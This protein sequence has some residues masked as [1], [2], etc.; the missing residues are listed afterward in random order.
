MR[1][2]GLRAYSARLVVRNYKLEK[3]S[4]SEGTRQTLKIL[5]QLLAEKKL[6]LGLTPN[7]T[8]M[9]LNASKTKIL[10]FWPIT[11]IRRYGTQRIRDTR[12]MF[13]EVSGLQARVCFQC[14]AA[15]VF[16][17]LT[18]LTE[19]LRKKAVR[20]ESTLADQL[21]ALGFTPKP[22]EGD[23]NCQFRAVAD[24]LYGDQE[25]Y[26]EIRELAVGWLTRNKGNPPHPSLSDEFALRNFLDTDV[27]PTWDHLVKYHSIDKNWGDHLT[28]IA[29]ANQLQISISIYSSL[30]DAPRLD[31]EPVPAPKKTPKRLYLYHWHDCHYGS[32]AGSPIKQKSKKKSK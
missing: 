15:K 5:R 14:D 9:I 21:K 16:V 7:S 28:L 4:R 32:L 31:I 6:V 29:I 20:E 18:R 23:G 1:T 12:E 27:F 22:I 11:H 2:T 19:H 24:Q 13:F 8:I 25:R 3:E 30:D 26:P 10:H 17:A